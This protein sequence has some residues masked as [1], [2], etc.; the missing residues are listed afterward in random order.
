ML[1]RHYLFLWAMHMWSE[2]MSKSG[3]S[4]MFSLAWET[5]EQLKQ[6][7]GSSL[8]KPPETPDLNTTMNYSRITY[9]QT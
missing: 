4:K 6:V 7:E 8:L 9:D 2:E 5:S 3:H 1:Q